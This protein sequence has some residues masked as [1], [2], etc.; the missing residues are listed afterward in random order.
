MVDRLKAVQ[1]LAGLFFGERSYL[2]NGLKNLVIKC[3]NHKQML[4][5]KHHL[6]KLFIAKFL[7]AVDES[8]YFLLKECMRETDVSQTD[9]ELTHLSNI[10]MHVRRGNFHRFLPL[11]VV[12][13]I[14]EKD[15]NE[16]DIKKV[17]ASSNITIE[18]KN[19]VKEWQLRANENYEKVFGGRKKEGISSKLSMG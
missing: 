6:D 4:R 19:R 15:G 16:R 7:Y 12:K 3:D 8:I 11:S 1:I 18:N 9:L 14:N 13:V 5:V 10:F 2:E 17:N